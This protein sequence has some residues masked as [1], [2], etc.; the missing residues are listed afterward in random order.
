MQ[1]FALWCNVYINISIYNG[2]NI[3]FL[4]SKVRS[5]TTTGLGIIP[6]FCTIAMIV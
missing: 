3:M 6:E 5:L 1:F 4:G 2:M